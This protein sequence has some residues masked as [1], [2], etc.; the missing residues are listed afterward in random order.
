MIYKTMTMADIASMYRFYVEN[1]GKL[2]TV[3]HISKYNLFEILLDNCREQHTKLL[4]P[5]QVR[6]LFGMKVI[7]DESDVPTLQ[8]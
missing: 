4:S 8:S 3:I 1:T 2:P 7:L 5:E 6:M